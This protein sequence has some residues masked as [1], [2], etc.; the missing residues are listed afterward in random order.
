MRVLLVDDN[1]DAA[2]TL[3]MVLEHLGADVHVA[4][5]G[6]EA[7]QMFDE[8]APSVVL[9]DIG[10]PGMDGYEVARRMRAHSRGRDAAIVALTGWDQEEDR[11]RAR[12]AGFE[13]HLVKPAE[14]DVLRRLLADIQ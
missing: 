4:Y 7:L 5:D 8:R 14:I 3:G 13:H 11:R 9:L 12:E 10:M 6:N 1:R 2:A